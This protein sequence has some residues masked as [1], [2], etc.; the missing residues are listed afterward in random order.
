[1]GLRTKSPEK[2]EK[3]R[4][5]RCRIDHTAAGE[6]GVELRAP[7]GQLEAWSVSDVAGVIAEAEAAARHGSYVAGF[8]AYEAAPAFDRA[9]R[10]Q[11]AAPADQS[12]PRLPLAWFGLFAQSVAVEPLRPPGANA[13]PPRHPCSP[14][15]PSWHCEMDEPTHA[16]GIRAIRASI[17]QGMA[18]LVNH[19]TR[20]RRPWPETEDP[21]TLYRQ[22]VAGHSGGYH[23]YIETAD[24]A[25][26]CGS[27]ELFFDFSAERLTA[28]PM[29]G[30]A[31]RG[32]WAA[33][34]AGHAAA[35]CASAKER[36]ENVMVVDMLR[37]D[38]GRIA[39]TGSVTVPHLWQVERHP[40]VWQ[41]T[42][43]VTAETPP[44][45]GLAEVFGALF[46]CASV[47]GAPK[48]SAM[49]IIAD[50]EHTPRGVYC[51]AVG[52]IRPDPSPSD[53][54]A[55]SARFAVGIRTAVVDKGGRV[56]EYGSGGGITADS[57]PASEWEEV[58]VKTKALVDPPPSA[59]ADQGLIETMGY[60]PRDKGGTVRNLGDHLARLAFSADYF[61]FPAPVQAQQRV[62]EAVAGLTAP[63]RVRLVLRP[64]GT[65]DLTTSVLEGDDPTRVQRLCVD[66]EPI[67][68][69]N[70]ALFHKT[71]DR[72][73][74]DER[75]ERHPRADDV[76]LVNER[77]ELTE[78]TRA[79]LAVCLGG[80]WCT[81]AL[82]CG[83]LPGIERAR[84]L[85]S[86]QLV[87][88][89]IRVEDLC[90]AEGVATLSSLR[91][92]RAAR[93]WPDCS[94]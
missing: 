37:N 4:L 18:Y 45:S 69:T 28:K 33:E 41:L 10:V 81:P 89:V 92:W 38:M 27:P 80:Q 60:H 79:N 91:G 71:T 62:T 26:A 43:T 85:A 61:G 56:V 23:A 16:A 58:L 54:S 1:M 93:I 8:V 94:C 46:P 2:P 48:V 68:S 5:V 32:R 74:Y 19:T 87:E 15:T 67:E 49:A 70:A 82:D 35:L 57:S 77:G 30:T 64:D 36:A 72:R 88:R 44:G 50:L 75:A 21:F 63:T 55:V 29:K 83:L 11:P 20:F 51:G 17:A 53:P 34:D 39:V 14:E 7:Q 22:L 84:L 42:S 65:L 47:T 12:I 73:R 40:S 90:G 86:G 76:V 78:T 6:G 52:V 25:V 3:P 13:E 24:W 31:P 59:G 66:P 9:F